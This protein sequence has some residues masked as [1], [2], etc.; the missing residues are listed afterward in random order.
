MVLKVDPFSDLI[1]CDFIDIISSVFIR[2]HKNGQSLLVLL[3]SEESEMIKSLEA[4]KI[5]INKIRYCSSTWYY[6]LKFSF[7]YAFSSFSFLIS[8]F[9]TLLSCLVINNKVENE[10]IATQFLDVI[11]DC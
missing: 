7:R 3:P 2:Y 1:I 9:F 4:K 11:C 10:L 6:I 8:L 5:P